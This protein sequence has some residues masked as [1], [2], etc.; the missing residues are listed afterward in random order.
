VVVAAGLLC[1]PSVAWADG[2]SSRAVTTV[3]GGLDGP[4]QVSDYKGHQLVVAES[5]SGEVSAVDPRT[6]TVTTLLTGLFAPQGVAYDDGLLFVALGGPPPPDEPGAVQPAPGQTTSALVVAKP[7]GTIVRTIDLKAYELA[8]NPD[9]QLQFLPDGS[10]PDSLSN[11]YSVLVQDRRILVADAG[12][13]DVLAIDR[14][15]WAISTFFVPKV[16]TPAEDPACNQPENDPGTVGCDPVPTSIV[17][18]PDGRLYVSTLGALAPGAARVYVLDQRGHVVRTIKGLSNA[19]GVAV[20]DHGTV[21]VTDL[22]QG[23][24]EGPPAAGF[25]PAT[26]GQ[27]VRVDRHGHRTYSQVTMPNG[28]LFEDGR[29]WASGWSIAGQLGQQHAGQVVRIGSNTF[30]PP[31]A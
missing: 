5:D 24:P 28:L 4:R 14:R 26:V 31:A 7:D 13:N 22:L 6:G 19:T 27:V 3:A 20:D 1:T 8:H 15:T 23:A 30:G 25:D 16:V 29:L 9:R 17:Q 11:P 18:G 21:Y 10:A 2:G 12:A